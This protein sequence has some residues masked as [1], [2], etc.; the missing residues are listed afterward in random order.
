MKHTLFGKIDE[1]E[2]YAHTLKSENVTLT[3][4]DYG[5]RIQS[6]VF[7]GTETVCG[8]ETLDGYL[9]DRDYH[10]AIV[11]RYA[12]RIAKG[13]FTL[14]GKAYTLA[15]NEVARGCHLHGGVCGFSSQIF[16]PIEES[17]TKIT[18]ALI[19]PDGEEGY[20]GELSVKVSYTLEN[21]AVIIEYT[22]KSTKD[23][24]INLT[25]HAYFNLSGVGT[26][27]LD[28][29]L[30]L[31]ADRIAEVDETLIPTGR[32]L[33]AKN[34]PFDFTKAK[35]IGQDIDKYHPQLKIGGGYD[36]GFVL[37]EASPAA[38][39]SSPESR[40]TM[41][42]ETSEGA[43]QIYTANFME[44]DNC[45][46]GGIPQKKREAIAIECNRLADSPNRPEFP[47]P[48]LKANET[49][50]QKTVYRFSKAE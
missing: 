2:V 11:G 7:D 47:S 35:L 48:I 4:I 30:L 29:T 26:S 32:L 37:F 25:N 19:S 38:I 40:I 24:V 39:L 45:F 13:S 41:T 28:H 49:Y 23:T 42:V 22:A 43:I 50:R 14:N 9:K 15:C 5:A 33:D 36:H 27:I 12:N 21:D 44:A 31:N 3:L 16:T 34:T 18:F 8:F 10:G 1:R 17:D 6:L 20:P 46:S